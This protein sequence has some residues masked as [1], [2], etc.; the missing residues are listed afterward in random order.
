MHSQNFNQ[1]M[2]IYAKIFTVKITFLAQ[3]V[4]L[5]Q[6]YDLYLRAK[7]IS[8]SK[9]FLQGLNLKTTAPALAAHCALSL[10]TKG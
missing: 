2:L 9:V 10:R 5:I 7:L 1:L 4:A 6:I 8:N 3:I